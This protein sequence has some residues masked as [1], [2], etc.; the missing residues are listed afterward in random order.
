VG[1]AFLSAIGTIEI[2]PLAGKFPLAAK[3]VCPIWRLEAGG[4]FP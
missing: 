3:N 1:Q 4:D 2:F